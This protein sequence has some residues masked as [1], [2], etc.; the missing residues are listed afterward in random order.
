VEKR[1]LRGGLIAL[2]N[3][4]KGDCSEAVVCLFF[5]VTRDM[6]LSLL[7][8]WSGIGPGCLAWSHHPWRSSKSV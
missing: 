8:E 2:Y 7:E 5:Q 1:R 6:T 3:Y 4:L